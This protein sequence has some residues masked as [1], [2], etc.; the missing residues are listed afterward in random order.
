MHP[1]LPDFVVDISLD[2]AAQ[3]EAVGMGNATGDALSEAALADE[4][5]MDNG[6][7]DG[8]GLQDI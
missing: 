6:M 4:G 7:G 5:W 8:A 1:P 2:E 3:Y